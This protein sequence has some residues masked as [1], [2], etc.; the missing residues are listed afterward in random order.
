M[1]VVVMSA[2]ERNEISEKNAPVR[3]D[4]P[5]TSRFLTDPLPTGRFKGGIRIAHETV[6]SS[7]T[8][9]INQNAQGHPVYVT[10]RAPMM[11]PRT[12]RAMRTNG[13]E[14]DDV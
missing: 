3:S 6:I 10:N 1:I 13:R 9:A 5:T 7:A 11:T 12:T 14:R 2:R 8:I 4:T